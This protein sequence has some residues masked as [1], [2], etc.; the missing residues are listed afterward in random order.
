MRRALALLSAAAMPA[1]SFAADAPV[2]DK[3]DSAFMYTAT[4]MVILMTIPGLALF[5]GGLVRTKNTLSVLMQVFVTFSLISVLWVVYGYSLAFTAGNAFLG[6]LDKL[7]LDGVTAASVAA[8]F[9]KGVY[10][11]ELFF[12]AFQCTFAAITCSLIVGAYAERMKFSAVLIFMVVWFTLSYLPMAHM[13]WYWDGPDAITDATTLATVLD[14]AGWLWAKGALDFAGGTV[15]HINAG[16]AG[17]VAA[18]VLGKRI[19]YGREAMAPHNLTL[20]M[21]GVALLWVGWFGFNAGSNLEAV[22]SA[23]LAMINTFVATAA[24]AVSWALVEQIHHKRASLLGAATG[25]VAGLV[26]ITPASGFAAPMTAIVLGLVVSPICYL[27]VS[28][29]KNR[30][31]YDDTLDVFG[32]HGI[33]GIVGAIGTGIVADPALGGQGFFD[34]TVFPAAVGEYDM[35]AQ[36]VTQLKAVLL[37]V[38]WSGIGSAVLFA[39]L[40][41]TIGLRPSEEAEREGLDL[42]EHGER[43]YN[44]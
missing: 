22:G 36:V 13:V 12:V 28:T 9:S 14:N 11:P 4:I 33:G 20:T 27:F 42:A 41:Y 23:P 2:P 16:V 6:S 44:Y 10:I 24:A 18:Y 5:Y 3:G 32:V 17:L 34:Y 25:A 15:V 43:A 26:A 1:F 7:F 19:G 40:K 21:V 38:A 29:I 35:A 31:R 8:T 30:L 39:V 37:T